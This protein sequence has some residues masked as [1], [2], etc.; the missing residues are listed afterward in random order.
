[1]GNVHKQP[2]FSH[3]FCFSTFKKFYATG[4]YKSRITLKRLRQKHIRKLAFFAATDNRARSIDDALYIS[5]DE[6]CRVSQRFY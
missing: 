1:M 6:R 5:F 2:Q 4:R 3:L